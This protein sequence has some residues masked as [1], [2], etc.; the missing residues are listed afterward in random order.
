[1]PTIVEVVEIEHVCDQPKKQAMTLP[2]KYITLM[3]IISV[4]SLVTGGYVESKSEQTNFHKNTA[5]LLILLAALL[6][7]ESHC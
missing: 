2:K 3:H 4:C 5:T 7:S 6:S 1:M